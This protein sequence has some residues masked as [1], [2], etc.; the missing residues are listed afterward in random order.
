VL[1]WILWIGALAALTLG[2]LAIRS[3]LEKAHIALVY[4]LLVL[5]GSSRGGR[6]VGLT[7]ALSAFFS[8]NFFFVPPYH[9]FRVAEPI[10]W[11]VLVAF[12]ITGAVAAQLLS[13]ARSE[14]EAARRRAD[15]VDRLA[16]LG[17]ETL[18]V[19]RAEDALTGI[20]EVI[21]STLGVVR[22]EIHLRDQTSGVMRPIAAAGSEAGETT[23]TVIPE[24][25]LVD[26]VATSGQAVIAHADG[27]TQIRQWPDT[28]SEEE[29]VVPGARTLL[30]PLRARDRTVGVLR[31]AHDRG[32]EL[33]AGQQRFLSALAYYAALGVERVRLV[34][35]AEEAEAFRQADELKNALLAS[36]SHDLRTPLTTIKALAH[37]IRTTGDD[38][39]AIIE[40]EADRLNRFV[41]DLLDLSRLAGGALILT[42]ELNAADDLVG[43]ALQRAS[44]AVGARRID[45]TLDTREP[46]LVGRFDFA[47]SLRI[48]V[49][50]I[51]NA[52]KYSPGDSPVEIAVHRVG[53]ALEFD[54]ADRGT[55]VPPNERER[56]FAPFYRRGDVPADA[57]SAGL[58]LSI[59]RQL[60]EAQHGSLE[61]RPRPGGGSH[62]V[63]RLPAADIIEATAEG[64]P[65]L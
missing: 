41:A 21:R 15:E 6:V 1:E 9:T 28:T 18:N 14:A 12:L 25:D 30:L 37:D 8:F 62:F 46:M 35:D 64:A 31:I 36:V 22:C 49:N 23:S 33:D 65:S 50:L 39:A 27:V 7:L 63:L 40:D 57:R 19:G 4:L 58:G 55:G 2:M 52:L 60:A 24:D 43:A 16:T 11:L 48:L 17:A 56:I 47:H 5:V 59:A 44:G 34:A 3:A 10:D 54:V 42:P 38:R 51:E 45:V 29:I 26:W 53:E 61:Y 13:R 20:A 32:L